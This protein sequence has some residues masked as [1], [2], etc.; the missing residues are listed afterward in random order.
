MIGTKL[1][2]TGRL[3]DTKEL[4]LVHLKLSAGDHVPAHDH[5]GQEVCFTPVAGELAVTLSGTETHQLTPGCVLHFAGEA[6]VAVQALADSEAFV[7]LI[8]RHQ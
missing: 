2:A 5:P 8:N 6:T 1:T 3:L 7:Y 4:M